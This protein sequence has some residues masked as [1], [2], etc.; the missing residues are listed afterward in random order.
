MTH[1]TASPSVKLRPTDGT[2]KDHFERPCEPLA[3][4]GFHGKHWEPATGSR[5]KALGYERHHM[6]LTC[7]SR[8]FSSGLRPVV[9]GWTAELRKKKNSFS[10]VHLRQC[11]AAKLKRARH[12]SAK[13]LF[14]D[15]YLLNK[16]LERHLHVFIYI[17]TGH[18]FLILDAALYFKIKTS[19][20]FFFLFC[21]F[22]L[23]DF[24]PGEQ[25]PR[26]ITEEWQELD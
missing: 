8:Q 18:I 5:I 26:S 10:S 15:F 20:V 9:F 25:S 3:H 14:T 12:C 11:C 13:M 19:K 4:R 21:L 23:C 1:G 16:F 24:R 17:S 7:Q 6:K 2:L 22:N